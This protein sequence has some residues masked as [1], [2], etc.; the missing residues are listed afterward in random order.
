LN[1]GILLVCD[2]HS[3][4]ARQDIAEMLESLGVLHPNSYI[5]GHGA[6]WAAASIVPPGDETTCGADIYSDGEDIFIWSGE[7]F[8]PE[9]WRT[10]AA[11]TSPQESISATILRRIQTL[12][13]EV[14]ANVDGAFA[15]AW[16]DSQNQRWHIFND[17]MG[18]IPLFWSAQDHRL[19]VAP[20]AQLAWLASGDPLEIDAVGVAD[21]LRTQNMVDDHTLIKGVQWLQGGQVVCWGEEGCGTYRYWNFHH[22]EPS[23]HDTDELID[24]ALNTLERTVKRQANCDSPL[25]LGISGGIDSRLILAVCE[26]IGRVPNCFTA[27]WA[28]SEDVRYGRK[29]ARI[30]GATHEWIPLD[31]KRLPD[32]LTE[33]IIETDGLHGVGHMAPGAMIRDYLQIHP[34]AV[35]L[36]GY[37]FGAS[38]GQYCPSD[39]DLPFDRPPHQCQWAR[40]LLHAGG[41][42]DFINSLLLPGLSIESHRRWQSHIDNKYRRAPADDDLQKA[43]YTIV[44]ERSGRI[45]VMGTSLLRRNCLVRTP[46]CD[47]LMLDWFAN[48]SPVLRRGKQLYTQ[49]FQK[50]FPHFARIQRSSNSGLP[51]S[52]N[53]FLRE[54]YWQKE[55]LHRWWTKKRHPWTR[56]WGIGGA[57]LHARTFEVW[58]ECGELNMLIAPDARILNWV[59]GNVLKQLWNRAEHDPNQAGPL[60]TLTTIEIMVRYLEQ[61]AGRNFQ[62][63]KH[64]IKFRTFEGNNPKT[65][66]KINSTVMPI[67]S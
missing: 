2:P 58:R 56:K 42:I 31:E 30:A 57:A 14:P 35:L 36:E 25:L 1:P 17:K 7:I 3:I 38:G 18:L 13:M 10:T 29:L 44:A 21:L 5:A 54:Y 32:L 63:I 9:H 16:Y 15:A 47:R 40:R 43:E 51:L 53:H 64:Q 46:A 34:K 61:F 24:S 55:K 66:D 26:S 19:V 59:D 4:Q 50:R 48:N 52:D 41:D 22:H 45:D 49:L 12:G 37:L 27:G 60:L 11:A 65:T 39:N 6:G 8:L 20:K 62:R 28:F 33:A 23:I 67:S